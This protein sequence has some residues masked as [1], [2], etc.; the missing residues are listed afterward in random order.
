MTKLSYLVED[1]NQSPRSLNSSSDL[2]E[3][4]KI[5]LIE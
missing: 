3:N 5:G 2:Q 1:L 4:V